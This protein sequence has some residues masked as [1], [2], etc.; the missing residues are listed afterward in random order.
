MKHSTIIVAI[1]LAL[2]VALPAVPAQAQLQHTFVSSQGLDTNNCSLAAPCRHLQAALLATTA[3]GEIAILDS[4]GYN[5]G[6]TVTITQ[7]VSIV[8][9]GG[10]EAEI[11]PPS[12]GVGVVINAG[13]NDAISLRGLTIDGGG[14]GFDGIRF[15]SGGSL[16]MENSV[17]RNLNGAGIAFFPNTASNLH[18]SNTLVANTDK[19]IQVFPSSTG[20]VYIVTAVF[21]HVEAINNATYG[22]VVNGSNSNAV[23]H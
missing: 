3:G 23:I 1:G 5:G 15:N 18:V 21:N 9:P 19:G 6:L 13:A 16:T 22:I 11:A 12:G 10:F 7:A 4:A 8:N 17:I 2:A 14:L 20:P